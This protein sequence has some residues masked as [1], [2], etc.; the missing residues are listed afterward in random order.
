MSATVPTH[1]HQGP[2]SELFALQDLEKAALEAVLDYQKEKVH[3]TYEIAHN[4]NKICLNTHKI[5]DNVDTSTLTPEML[6]MYNEL[7][8]DLNTVNHI[9]SIPNHY[10][11]HHHHHQQNVNETILKAAAFFLK[12]VCSDQLLVNSMDNAYLYTQCTKFDSLTTKEIYDS[13]TPEEQLTLIDSTT[14]FFMAK[15]EYMTGLNTFVSLFE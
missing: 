14:N 5:I 9:C 1:T 11:L 10:H 12:H 8:K 3:R 13:F 6:T 2:I 7:K 4:L 15:P